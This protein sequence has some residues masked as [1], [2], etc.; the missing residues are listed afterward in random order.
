MADPG[1]QHR[2]SIAG[3]DDALADKLRAIAAETP[4]YAAVMEARRATF[5]AESAR[6]GGVLDRPAWEAVVS[7]WGELR[8]PYPL[9]YAL[10]RAA[11]ATAADDDRDEAAALL[12]RAAELTDR[13][14]AKPLRAEVDLLARRSRLTVGRGAAPAGRPAFGLTAREQEVLRLVALGRS[15]R[16]IAEE[17]FI[18]AKTASV[19][20]SN[21]LGKLGVVA[22]LP[23]EAIDALATRAAEIPPGPSQLFIVPWGGAVRRFGAEHSPLAGREA[24]FIVHPLL[25]WEDSSD[26]E[27]CRALGRAFRDDMGPWSTGA[28]YPNFLGNEGATRMSA[29]FGASAERLAAVKAEWDP[30]GVFRTQ[31]ASAPETSLTTAGRS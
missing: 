7:A 8:R 18:S 11:E 21:I 20:V 5:A 10:L 28:T 29:A 4:A 30:H 24:R 17:L 14:G 26:D 3:P 6:A 15:N 13:L 31:P 25:L 23:D 22:E 27:R 16:D 12:T 19:H 1:R 2:A 9:A